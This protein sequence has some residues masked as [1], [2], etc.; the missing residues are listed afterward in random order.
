MRKYRA[1]RESQPNTGVTDEQLDN[2]LREGAKLGGEAAAQFEPLE[3]SQPNTPT[4]NSD[5]P[6]SSLVEEESADGV[7]G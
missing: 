3:E 4:T 2:L 6:S 5:S 7:E 1:A